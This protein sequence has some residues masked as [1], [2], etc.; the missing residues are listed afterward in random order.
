MKKTTVMLKKYKVPHHI[1]KAI[2]AIL[3]DLELY[4]RTTTTN[5]KAVHYLSHRMR[6][7]KKDGLVY[8]RWLPD[9]NPQRHLIALDS[10]YKLVRISENKVR[11]VCEE[12]FGD[13]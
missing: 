13:E 2:D 9:Y 6:Y 12:K 11:L 4:G 8:I 3:R 10:K 5:G 7:P 1:Q